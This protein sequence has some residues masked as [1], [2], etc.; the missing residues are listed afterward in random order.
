[1]DHGGSQASRVEFS[2]FR[3]ELN[4]KKREMINAQEL[5]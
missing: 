4:Y 5:G 3:D 1:M 2:P